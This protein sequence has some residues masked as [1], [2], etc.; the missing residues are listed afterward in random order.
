M[1]NVKGSGYDP[2]PEDLPFWQNG[3]YY[4]HWLNV[5]THI[6]YKWSKLGWLVVEVQHGQ[7]THNETQGKA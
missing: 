2:T 1:R 7:E 5:K 6:L 4:R 3:M